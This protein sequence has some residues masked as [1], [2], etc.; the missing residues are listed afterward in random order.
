M[1]LLQ[2]LRHGGGGLNALG[3][4]AVAAL[5]N[6]ASPDVDYAF[7]PAEVISMFDNVFPGTK[8]SYDSLKDRLEA[9]NTRGCDLEESDH[10]RQGEEQG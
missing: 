1:T 10:G 4:E 8:G 5:L 6:A 7:T 2:V 9:E 3:R